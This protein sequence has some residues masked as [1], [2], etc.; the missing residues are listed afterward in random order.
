MTNNARYIWWGVVDKKERKEQK[1]PEKE[2]A[3]S[4]LQ[5]YRRP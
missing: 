1:N 2:L 5:P 4:A 3:D